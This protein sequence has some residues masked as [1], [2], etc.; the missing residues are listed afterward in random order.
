MCLR[1]PW[2]ISFQ[3]TALNWGWRGSLRGGGTQMPFWAMCTHIWSRNRLE[4]GRTRILFPQ[5]F[6]DENSCILRFDVFTTPEAS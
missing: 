6:V 2:N 5:I 1:K 3:K 4:R